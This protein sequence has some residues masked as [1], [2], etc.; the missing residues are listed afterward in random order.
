MTTNVNALLTQAVKHQQL[1]KMAEAE[2]AFE[3]AL[4]KA[5]TNLIAIYSLALILFN[6]NRLEAALKLAVKG[7]VS[8][9]RYA[10]LWFLRG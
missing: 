6:S 3:K 1:G 4:V 8:H 10:P 5:P 7:V 2:A 9:P